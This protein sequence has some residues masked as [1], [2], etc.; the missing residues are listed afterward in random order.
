MMLNKLPENIIKEKLKLELTTSKYESPD[1]FK[2]YYKN[3]K[4][5]VWNSYLKSII[6]NLNLV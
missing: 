3:E 2:S 4:V 5:L 1:V 6:Q